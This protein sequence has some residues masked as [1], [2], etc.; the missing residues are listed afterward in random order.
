MKSPGG[1]MIQSLSVN[2]FQT[3]L[4]V[5]IGTYPANLFLLDWITSSMLLVQVCPPPHPPLHSFPHLRVH[6]LW[7]VNQETESVG[8]PNAAKDP[9]KN[10]RTG[11]G[12]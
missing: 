9:P 7:G 4:G 5:H 11:A 12:K 10:E 3:F 1:K 2:V 6:L 8:K